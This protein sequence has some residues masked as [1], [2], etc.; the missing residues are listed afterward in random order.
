MCVPL[1]SHL[2]VRSLNP[3][4]PGPIFEKRLCFQGGW[5][6]AASDFIL[7]FM[8]TASPN[9]HKIKSIKFY[10]PMSYLVVFLFTLNSCISLSTTLM[11]IITYKTRSIHLAHSKCLFKVKLCL[12]H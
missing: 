2:H 1:G 3:V 5:D 4:Q 7:E 6:L 11:F 9:R 8:V 10:I 12:L